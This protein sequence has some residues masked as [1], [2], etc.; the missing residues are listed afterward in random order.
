M[1][2]FLIFLAFVADVLTLIPL[3]GDFVGWIFWAI[4]AI[5]FWKLGLGLVNWRR[6]VPALISTV[7]ELF[8]AVQELPTIIAGMVAILILSRIEDKTGL[9]VFPSKSKPGVTPPR[10]K[11]VPPNQNGVRISRTEQENRSQGEEIS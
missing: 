4:M 10:V 11:R 3:A 9:K 6:F 1:G 8:P 7:A 5:I 2:I